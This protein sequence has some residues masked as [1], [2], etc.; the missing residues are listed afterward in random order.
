MLPGQLNLFEPATAPSTSAL[1]LLLVLPHA[2][3]CGSTTGAI[4]SSA[5]PHIAK[6]ICANCGRFHSWMSVAD[7]NFIAEIIDLSGRPASPIV[8]RNSH[9]GF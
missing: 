3:Q 6:R 1:G 2:C 7:F 4:G 9:E 5:G 8:V